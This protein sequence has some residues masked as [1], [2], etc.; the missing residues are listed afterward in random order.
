M[1]EPRCISAHVWHALCRDLT[2]LPV[3]HALSTNGMN[4]YE[5]IA[6]KYDS[7]GV[8]WVKL[9]VRPAGGGSKNFVWGGAHGECGKERKW[10]TFK[11]FSG[12]LTSRSLLLEIMSIIRSAVMAI[13]WLDRLGHHIQR[14]GHGLTLPNGRDATYEYCHYY[15]YYY[16]YYYCC[17]CCCCIDI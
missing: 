8:A 9:K 16:Y 10:P 3:T 4:Q 1:T 17:C 11:K 15:Y 13:C 7:S 2:V 14:S 6:Q 12:E 5:F